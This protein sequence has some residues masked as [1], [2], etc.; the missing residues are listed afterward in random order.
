MKS[1]VCVSLALHAALFAAAIQIKTQ[2]ILPLAPS[3]THQVVEMQLGAVPRYAAQMHVSPKELSNVLKALP[4][5]TP[6]AE[7]PVIN[8]SPAATVSTAADNPEFSPSILSS[9][10]SASMPKFTIAVAA[11]SRPSVVS[12]GSAVHE[13]ATPLA[14]ALPYILSSPP[15]AYPREA[16]SKGWSGKVRVRVLISEQGTVQDVEIAGSSGHAALDDAALKA[17]RQWRFHPACKD[18]Q[19]VASWVVVP[20]LF[21]L[22]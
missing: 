22:D 3:V 8:L 6:V 20:V 12:R 9:I 13:Q 2:R 1:I 14:N 21:R 10:S 18:G 11:S 4:T 7:T 16:R 5:Q 15:P 17:L 19:V